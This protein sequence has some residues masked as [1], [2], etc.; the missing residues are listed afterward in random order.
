MKRKRVEREKIEMDEMDELA[1]QEFD[2][3]DP[4]LDAIVEMFGKNR[5]LSQRSDGETLPEITPEFLRALMNL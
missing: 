5:K 1:E 3:G 4:S 2:D